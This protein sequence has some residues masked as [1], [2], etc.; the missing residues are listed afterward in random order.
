MNK[1]LRYSLTLALL[2]LSIYA[3]KKGN[4]IATESEQVQNIVPI[5]IKNWFDQNNFNNITISGF[6][7]YTTNTNRVNSSNSDTKKIKINPDW[8]Q[9][10]SYT[11]GDSTIVEMP[12]MAEHA[13]FAF[14]AKKVEPKQFDFT[15]PESYTSLLFIQAKGHTQGVYMTVLADP[16]YLKGDKEKLKKNTF[17]KKEADFSGKVFFH[18]LEGYFLN[19]YAYTQGKITG[20]IKPVV[21]KT[22]K[23]KTQAASL[24]QDCYTFTITTY[25]EQCIDWYVNGEY[26]HTANCDTWA[27]ES[28][29]EQCSY[30]YYESGGGGGGSAGNPENPCAK[31][32]PVA[33][34]AS[35]KLNIVAPPDEPTEPGTTEPP[36][37]PC[38]EET[39]P[40][41]TKEIN[42]NITDTCLRKTINEALGAN[43][44]V[45]GFLADVITKFAGK[46]NDIVIN[47]NDGYTGG[48]AQTNPS[49]MPNGAFKAE[50]NF[51]ANYFSDVSKELVVAQLMHEVVHAY[52]YA[53]CN[54][55]QKLPRDQQHN[56]LYQYL[57]KDMGIYL[58]SKYSMPENDAFGLAW[59]GV[60]E[61]FK[62]VNDDF[63]FSTL[64]GR[65]LTKNEL[66][67]AYTPYAYV[68]Q[69][70]KGSPNCK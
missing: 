5:S 58:M 56:Y 70:S 55:Y 33:V 25:W 16:D 18:T 66:T 41:S 54:D 57:I 11:I 61:V 63:K 43:K 39:T 10:K 60:G 50:I 4:L 32:T 6:K 12:L 29:Y 17:R 47:I 35:I 8:S 9:A 7:V 52:L 30:S 68:G 1:K 59:S 24:I 65:I 3:C 40:V 44:Y 15:K 36:L 23:I 28:T 67:N 13:N 46:N 42:N 19:G 20:K 51:N 27:E 69:G 22:S 38:P 48:S 31:Q 64:E 26:S 37:P 34:E 2:C 14:S 21:G 49:F 62:T 45:Q 53:T